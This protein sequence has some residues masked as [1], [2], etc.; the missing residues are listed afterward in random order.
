M[1][2]SN[3][4]LWKELL[5]FS[6]IVKFTSFLALAVVF[7][8]IIQ[9]LV[10]KI[11]SMFIEEN[12]QTDDLLIRKIHRWNKISVVLFGI[13]NIAFFAYLTYIMILTGRK[14]IPGWFNSALKSYGK[15]ILLALVTFVIY[16]LG[17]RLLSKGVSVLLR[18][19]TITDEGKQRLELREK[20]L[21]HIISYLLL[22][23]LTVF[24]IYEA[25]TSL[26][27]DLKAVLA[28]AGLASLAIGFGAQ[29]LVKDYING[30][31]IILEDQFAVGD[32]INVS[33]MGGF[34]EKFTLRNTQLRDTHGTLVFIPNNEIST[35]KNLT[36]DW[37]R[38][39]FTIGVDYATDVPKA[40]QMMWEELELLK[41]EMPEDLLEPAGQKPDVLALDSFG[42]SSLNL[43]IWF[44]T[45][46]I[47]QWAVQ[48]AY[49][50]K[51]LDRFNKEG[52]V[53]PFPQSTLS[54]RD[55]VTS[56]LQ[57]ISKG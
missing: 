9:Y 43:R 23:I 44:K 4:L 57:H 1:D 30:F 27:L 36:K 31:F 18:K 5:T 14:D 39:D 55:E 11:T 46:P 19:T 22:V 8:I 41:K 35:V 51:L 49:N 12:E 47:R 16:N 45:K 28:T 21:D 10:K 52:V 25:L 3:I 32:V 42:N 7:Q 2:F 50:E 13:L 56:Q 34:V 29:S 54:L 24:F 20:T 40:L 53:I 37:S 26:G 17:R 33:G 38:V 6:N 48:R 15:I